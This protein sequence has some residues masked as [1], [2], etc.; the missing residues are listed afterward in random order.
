MAVLQSGA[1]AATARTF[2]IEAIRPPDLSRAKQTETVQ[3]FKVHL[4]TGGGEDLATKI[5]FS[6]RGMDAPARAEPVS[7]DLLASYR[8]APLIVPHYTA[9]AAAR[10]KLRAL[11]SR[12]EVAA[13]DVFDLF[14]LSTRPGVAGGEAARGVDRERLETAR[15]RTY[16]VDYERYR[17]TVVGYLEDEDRASYER[18]EAWDEIRL[19][20][21]SL[22]ERG[23]GRGT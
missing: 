11:A 6:R 22:I 18:R 7:P 3:R 21:V 15:E 19:V 16:S 14:V 4:R 13:R 5:E 20:V 10:Q 8:M 1:L 17:D 23:L 9:L 2:G 12:R